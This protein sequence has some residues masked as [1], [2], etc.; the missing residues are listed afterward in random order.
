M[1]ALH[2]VIDLG[3]RSPGSIYGDPLDKGCLVWRM[4]GSFNTTGNLPR[5]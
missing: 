3:D 4:R 2:F 5:R 1:D